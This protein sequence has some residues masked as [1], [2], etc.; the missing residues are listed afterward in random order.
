MKQ[1]CSWN[2]I[3]LFNQ[4]VSVHSSKEYTLYTRNSTNSFTCS[5]FIIE[6]KF[7][8]ILKDFMKHKFCMRT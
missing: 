7:D 5:I 2:S 6:F 4:A 1:G 8:E 3:P